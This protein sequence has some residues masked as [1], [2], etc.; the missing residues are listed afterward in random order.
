MSNKYPLLNN[1]EWL[2]NKYIIEGLGTKQICQIVGA[3]TPNSVRQ[4]LIKH[5]IPVRTIGDGLRSNKEGDGLVI[6]TEDIE[7]CLLGD[8]YLRKWSKDSPNGYPYF[9]KRNKF[10]DHIKYV[11]QI[12][13][14]DKWEKRTK[15]S[16]ETILGKR[17]TIFSLRSLS[18]KQLN[19]FYER[20]YPVWDNYRKVIPSDI[21][22]TPRMMLHWFLDDGSSYQ[23]RRE[24]KTKQ[25]VI[26]LCSESFSEDNQQMMINKMKDEFGLKGVLKKV[27]FGTGYR[28]TFSQSQTPLFYDI[29][30]ACPVP[31]MEYKWK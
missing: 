7:G 31:S 15:E 24:S 4:A 12:L 25:V 9:A 20:W 23:R 18:N 19:P 17:T 11:A 21:H 10:Y 14:G 6:S 27:P 16:K 2:Y 13:F 1:K 8:G 28:I 22:P 30:G 29:I 3:K 5:S 26:T